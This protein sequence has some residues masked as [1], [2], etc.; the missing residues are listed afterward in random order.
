MFNFRISPLVFIFNHIMFSIPMYSYTRLWLA[1]ETSSNQAAKDVYL[2]GCFQESSNRFQIC[3]VNV[4]WVKRWSSPSWLALQHKFHV[5][6][7]SLDGKAKFQI[8]FQDSRPGPLSS[9]VYSP[10]GGVCFSWI[11][12]QMG[13]TPNVHMDNQILAMRKSFRFPQSHEK[14]HLTTVNPWGFGPILNLILYDFQTRHL[15]R[16]GNSQFLGFVHLF[17]MIYK[18]SL[19]N[20]YFKGHEESSYL[21][22]PHLFNYSS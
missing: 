17:G 16:F 1:S 6:Y 18:Y 4:H 15:L 20:L 21:L 2:A 22:I 12:D 7:F 13:P 10:F 3:F 19:R 8:R 11:D 5:N 9:T 14:P